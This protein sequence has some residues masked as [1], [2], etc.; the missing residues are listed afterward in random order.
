MGR[1]FLKKAGRSLGGLEFPVAASFISS[2][3]LSFG[4]KLRCPGT[5]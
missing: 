2:S 3:A 4:E 1:G 5:Q